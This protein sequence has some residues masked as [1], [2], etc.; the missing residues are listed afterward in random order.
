MSGRNEIAS[1]Y[2]A[3]LPSMQ[4]I[5]GQIAK[6]LHNEGITSVFDSYGKKA[7]KSLSS[8]IGK[9]FD[10]EGFAKGLDKAG[11]NFDKAGKLLTRYVTKPTIA[12]GLAAK[13]TGVAIGGM[14]ANLGFK[15]LVSIDNAKSKLYGLG[16]TT[17]NVKVIMDN[18]LQSVLGTAYSLGD[19]ASIAASAVAAG[20]KPGK[21]LTKY[22]SSV[23]DAAAIAGV[24]LD[25]MGSI[26]NRVT[27]S[28][29]AYTMEINML[30]DR[31]I[32]IFE[33]L[34]KE[35]NTSVDGV[36]KLASEGKI[37]SELY[38]RAIEKNIGGAAKIMGEISFAGAVE[39]LKAA[40]GRL[41]AN[42]LDGDGT[43]GGMFSQLKPLIGDAT[44]FLDK[45]GDKAKKAG[46][47]AGAAF[48]TAIPRIKELIGV[49]FP[50]ASGFDIMKMSADDMRIKVGQAFTDLI[51]KV[52]EIKNWYT[53]LS[54]AQKKFLHNLPLIAI[55]V[56]P[57][58]RL[59]GAVLKIAS[60]FL[61]GATSLKAFNALMVA[62][63]AKS[64]GM[65]IVSTSAISNLSRFLTLAATA[66]AA[67]TAF[68]VA[69]AA[70][71]GA[72]GV[73]LGLAIY[74]NLIKPLMDASFAAERAEATADFYNTTIGKSIN[75]NRLAADAKDRNTKATDAL[76]NAETLAADAI[77]SAES[78]ALSLERAQRG[79]AEALKQYGQG[80]LEHREALNY[81]KVAKNQLE[82]ATKE[83]KEAQES[84]TA[85]QEEARKS[86]ESLARAN[87]AL[88]D[89]QAHTRAELMKTADGMEKLG[90]TGGQRYSK[91]M[92]DQGPNA[93]LAGQILGENAKSGAA[94]V[95]LNGVGRD[96]VGGL[97]AGMRSRGQ[98]VAATTRSL[99]NSNI[100]GTAVK[101]A[102]IKSPSR[103]T[104]ELG[105][106]IAL[107]FAVGMDGKRAEVAKSSAALVNT[108]ST[109]IKDVA[110]IR[111][112][113][114]V[115]ARL[116]NNFGL[117]FA[118]GIL[119]MTRETMQAAQ[120]LMTKSATSAQRNAAWN[121]AGIWL[122]RSFTH[123]INE[124][125]KSIATGDISNVNALMEELVEFTKGAAQ[126]TLRAFAAQMTKVAG[127]VEKLNVRLEEEKQKLDS[128][129]ESL[130]SY[131]ENIKTKLA[132]F[133]S[134]VFSS[135]GV[136]ASDYLEALKERLSATQEYASNMKKLATLG[137][138]QAAIDAIASQDLESGSA[139]IESLLD[140]ADTKIIAEMNRL[141]SAIEAEGADLGATLGNAYI[142]PQLDAQASVIEQLEE[143]VSTAT[144]A[145]EQLGRSL[146]E[147]MKQAM[148]GAGTY[149]ATM[150]ANLAD[151]IK[152]A[153]PLALS[154][155]QNLAT[156]MEGLLGVAITPQVS[157][158]AV[159][160]FAPQAQP[161]SA[162]SSTTNYNN[163]NVTLDASDVNDIRTFEEFI[164]R[165]KTA[166]A[167]YA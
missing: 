140:G 76:R 36:R 63:A 33:W 66:P 23:G 162:S 161:A 126:N 128:L 121:V 159:S 123:N 166:K 111:S 15:R 132:D 17:E 30:A 46:E 113:S 108:A 56:G 34:A 61:K 90:K 124:A 158:G 139:I 164:E 12:A 10:M 131:V 8:S 95:S 146:A 13:A 44:T 55:G 11:S 77:L 21:D 2:I 99:I 141:Y 51:N 100:R 50:A 70:L 7:G 117:G 58:L 73:G 1:A 19:A 28:Q 82:K 3:L 163:I 38:F 114:R 9:N 68:T 137:L 62:S 97:I 4:G 16:H 45:F 110:E 89:D 148:D 49:L 39:N 118:K 98:E 22:L 120:D 25:E 109:A 78:A 14:F 145:G 160:T 144:K 150:V 35:A 65:Q 96:I 48:M 149:G 101:Y 88:A 72:V 81:E 91:L 156:K 129:R 26:F 75:L 94:G 43:G 40:A 107:G 133:G 41:G 83:A 134:S 119:E 138:N 154:A 54:D 53:N 37:S 152:S 122:G 165:L 85:S 92:R 47:L 57:A 74:N 87:K 115:A 31:S 27:T 116:G 167:V 29:R 112:P 60:A 143:Q 24:G 20:V 147:A 153:T 64:V 86:S 80:S 127:V 6:S 52:I 59:T 102:Q 125:I 136:D 130:K 5:K 32:P 69:A 67:L 151:G 104:A 135:V 84:L 105:E 157:S 155:A 93:R 103:M 142:K 79:V 71:S 42:F 106:Y 18:A